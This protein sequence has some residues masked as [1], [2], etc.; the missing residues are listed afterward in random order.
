MIKNESVILIFLFENRPCCSCR[1][2]VT[3]IILLAIS[4]LLLLEAIIIFLS[5]FVI[6]LIS[7]DLLVLLSSKFCKDDDDGVILISGIFIC[8]KWLLLIGF[9]SCGV[10]VAAGFSLLF[11]ISVI[12]GVKLFGLDLS[13]SLIF[14]SIARFS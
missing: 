3:F 11:F 10:D 9:L 12:V 4:T 2:I 1:L 14:V 8:S 13:F 5:L 6:L 7:S